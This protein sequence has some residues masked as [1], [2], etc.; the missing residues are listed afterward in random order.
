MDSAVL[1]AYGW[2]DLAARAG[3]I[4]LNETNEDDHTYQGRL[5]W[6]SGFRDEVLTRLLAINAERHAD[7][8]RCGVAP[9]LKGSAEADD[10]D[11]DDDV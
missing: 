9:G 6:P 5:F 3:S 4:F 10:M 11:D 1:G 7:E 8:V 2:K